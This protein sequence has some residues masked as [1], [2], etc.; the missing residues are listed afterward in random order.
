MV[1]IRTFERTMTQLDDDMKEDASSFLRALGDRVRTARGSTGLSRRALSERTNISERYLAQLEGGSG[2]IS[3]SLLNRV[4]QALNVPITALVADEDPMVALLSTA[5]DDKRQRVISLLSP[6]PDHGGRIALIGLRGAGKSTLGRLVAAR[7]GVPF[8]ELADQIAAA[9]G[10]SV[11]ELFAL[12]GLDGYRRLEREALD[13]MISGGPMVL[14]VAGGIVEHPETFATLLK[15]FQTVW[16]RARPDEHMERVRA[17]GDE[18]PMAGNPQ[19]MR[20]LRAL[21]TARE[22][23]YARASLTVD[24]SGRTA[25]ESLDAVLTAIA[26]G[27]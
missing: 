27:V 24:T 21:L 2:N 18:R 11:S 10:V 13:R 6:E 12:Y 19:A 4:A 26:R 20:D 16:L 22:S 9:A 25:R 3:I 14:A 15:N 17:Q 8:H 5:P 1:S 7:L 23:E